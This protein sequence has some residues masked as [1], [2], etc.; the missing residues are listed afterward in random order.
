VG[1]GNNSVQLTMGNGTSS[2]ATFTSS[3]TFGYSQWQHVAVTVQRPGGGPIGRFYVNGVSAG[4]FVPPA[5]SVS[6]GIPLLLGSYRQNLGPCQSCEV[7]LDEIEIF[8]DVVSPSDIKA[9][10]DAGS[11]GK[12]P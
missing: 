12:C 7:A 1:T 9:I 8:D 2:P 10:F 6:N 3:P 4:T 5:T 11:A